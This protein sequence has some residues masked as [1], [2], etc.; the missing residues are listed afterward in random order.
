MQ[1]LVS[2]RGDVA[3]YGFRLRGIGGI[4]DIGVDVDDR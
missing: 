3:M 4:V 1:V 2:S